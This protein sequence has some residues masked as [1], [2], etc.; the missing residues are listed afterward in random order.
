MLKA[1]EKMLPFVYKIKSLKKPPTMPHISLTQTQIGEL[2][3]GKGV[4]TN[5]METGKGMGKW[6]GANLFQSSML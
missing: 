6:R 2:Y 3:D 1:Q 4:F 5:A